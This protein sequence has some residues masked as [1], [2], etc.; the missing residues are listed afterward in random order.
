M[1]MRPRM[2][3]VINIDPFFLSKMS[4]WF[5]ADV[6]EW[7]NPSYFDEAANACVSSYL[8]EFSNRDVIISQLTKALESWSPQVALQFEDATN[9][10]WLRNPKFENMLKTIISNLI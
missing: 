10:D 1:N 5:D 8:F 2:S 3:Q 4:A 7:E 6:I 9:L